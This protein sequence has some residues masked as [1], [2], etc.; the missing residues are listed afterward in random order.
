[1]L[2]TFRFSIILEACK[3]CTG[4]RCDVDDKQIRKLEPRDNK[5]IPMEIV[6]DTGDITT[7]EHE[8]LERWRRDFER[9]Y[10]G[11]NHDDFETDNEP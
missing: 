5:H 7:N 9:L 8:V 2:G 1:M 10:N 11:S 6:T 4:K 3:G